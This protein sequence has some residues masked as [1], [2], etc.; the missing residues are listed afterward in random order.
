M[1][2]LP[3]CCYVPTI[4]RTDDIIIYHSMGV[5]CSVSH[6]DIS[7]CLHCCCVCFLLKEQVSLHHLGNAGSQLENM[8]VFCLVFFFFMK[9]AFLAPSLSSALAAMFSLLY[10]ILPHTG[11]KG[12]ILEFSF[13][14]D[15][16]YLNTKVESI[17]IIIQKYR[18]HENSC[19]I[20]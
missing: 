15:S 1:L 20:P 9:K 3:V 13:R 14:I 7:P 10:C 12:G 2:L 17:A 4:Y 11:L 18:H 16:F 6:T 19:S 8:H 5:L